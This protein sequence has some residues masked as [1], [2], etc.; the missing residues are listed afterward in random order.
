MDSEEVDKLNKLLVGMGVEFS[1]PQRDTCQAELLM[2]SIYHWIGLAVTSRVGYWNWVERWSI[3]VT[4][5]C[6]FCDTKVQLSNNIECSQSSNNFDHKI[7]REG[8][9]ITDL[10]PSKHEPFMINKNK[11][12]LCSVK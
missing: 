9:G 3:G 10:V 4:I 8:L 5:V 1:G 11:L 2:K 12:R 7:Y 6:T